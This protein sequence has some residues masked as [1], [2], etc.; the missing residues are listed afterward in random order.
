MKENAV[1][2]AGGFECV[3]CNSPCATCI[4]TPDY[5]TS[6]LPGFEFSGWKCAQTFRF[7][8]GLTLTV[9]L[10]VFEANYLS[11][12]EVFAAAL[13]VQDSNAITINSIREGS[14]LFDG[15]A[16]PTGAQGSSQA[17]DQLKSLSSLV[18]SGNIAGM[19]VGASTI[20]VE[21]GAVG[22]ATLE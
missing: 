4:N 12:I 11:L 20:T 22:T 17:G 10:A 21:N 8:F 6:C 19:V 5:C 16:A 13:K 9:T 18:N 2:T 15:S 1:A 14:V 7:S 3:K